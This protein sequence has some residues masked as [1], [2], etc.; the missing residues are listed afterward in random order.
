MAE[1]RVACRTPAEGRDGV[2]N[3][4]EWKFDAVQ[5]AIL[6]VLGQGP[7][8]FS[9]LPDAVKVQLPHGDLDRLGSVGWHVTTVKLEM[10]VRGELARVP[11]K[12]PQMVTRVERA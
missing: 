9:E 8:A 4:P 5:G 12:G 1:P 10:E 11:G 7:V 2:T 3:I 6:E